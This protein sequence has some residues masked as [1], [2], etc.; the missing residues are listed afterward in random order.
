M[1]LSLAVWLSKHPWQAAILTA[2]FGVFS[3]VLP[4]LV[5]VPIATIAL[6]TLEHG[7]FQGGKV[8]IISGSAMIA[9]LSLM[10]PES[11][12]IKYG[13][14]YVTI[15]LIFPL[16][17]SDLLRRTGSLNLVFQLLLLSGFVSIAL[18]YVLLPN[19]S[20][21][22]ESSINQAYDLLIKNGVKVDKSLAQ[23]WVGRFW[24]VVVS[25]I[26]FL[27]LCGVFLGRWW[28]ALIHSQG[29]FGR[30]FRRLSSGV[31]LGSLQFVLL[32]VAFFTDNEWIN[33]MS[34]VAL[35]GLALQGLAAAH[36]S[37]AD[38]L[39]PI[40]LLRVIYILLLLPTKYPISDITVLI[41]ACWGF[42]VFWKRMRSTGLSV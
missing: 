11:D 2:C 28:Q 1:H 6:I 20:A 39:L 26:T 16:L 4:P 3:F 22:W 21:L 31:V 23:M 25:G 38:G 5:I 18:V 36:R 13:I 32:S 9:L 41:L 29:S 10:W 40:G 14:G 35:L 33:N 7:Y 15:I 24:G 30:E 19:P 34:R 37:K 42:A 27:V 17:L 8:M 12:A